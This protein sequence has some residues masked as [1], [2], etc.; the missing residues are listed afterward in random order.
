MTV[1]HGRPF[2]R[3]GRPGGTARDRG[4]RGPG[5][6]GLAG[7]RSGGP[8]ARARLPRRR[9][10]L[11]GGGPR[12]R[13]EVPRLEGGSAA[14]DL[15]PPRAESL[16]RPE[17]RGAHLRR[18]GAHAAHGAAGDPGHRSPAARV[19]ALHHG[20]AGTPVRLGRSLHH[21]RPRTSRERG[22][23]PGRHRDLRRAVV[24]GRAAH[25][26]DRPAPRAGRIAST[27]RGPGDERDRAARPS[28]VAPRGFSSRSPSVRMAVPAALRRGSHGSRGLRAGAAVH[29]RR[30]PGAHRCSL[31]AEPAGWTR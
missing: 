27:G 4:Q 16:P 2:T 18:A 31:P 13:H 1:R 20:R 10:S 15:H 22:P 24:P 6:Q 14:R 7:A 19:R 28:P 29:G 26:R 9:L 12:Q 23:A 30:G 17:P 5:P 8:E 25:L 11:R 3:R 21:A